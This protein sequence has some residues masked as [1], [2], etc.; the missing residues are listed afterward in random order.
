MPKSKKV[1]LEDVK[2]LDETKKLK[3][4]LKNRPPTPKRGRLSTV[5]KR[6][7]TPKQKKFVEA[8]VP[9][10][11]KRGAVATAAEIAYDVKDRNSANVTG[12]AA[13]KSPAVQSALATLFPESK[14][15]Q[16]VDKLFDMTQGA[17]DEKNQLDAIKVWTSHAV[18]KQD[19]NINFNQI[20]INQR[21][22]Y[23]I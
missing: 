8:L 16:V 3:K 2:S 11:D 12:I 13:M 15:K 4:Y 14:T 23:D 10:K 6:R 7:L 21:E 17:E 1:H 5:Q 22:K 9:I 20:Q 18:P 19:G